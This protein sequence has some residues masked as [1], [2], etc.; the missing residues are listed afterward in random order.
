VHYTEAEA[1]NHVI[2]LL[3]GEIDKSLAQIQMLE[4]RKIS[5][6]QIV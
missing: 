5:N 3:K 4:E 1:I 2:S 6:L